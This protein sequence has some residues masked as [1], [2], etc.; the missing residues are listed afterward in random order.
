MR[1]RMNFGIVKTIL[2]AIVALGAIA[3]MGVDIAML[4]G[5]EGLASKNPANI[6]IAAVSLCAA[7]II[8]LGALLI[9]LNSSY[10]FKKSYMRAVLGVFADK[11]SYDDI[12]C[13]KQNS[14]NKELYLITKGIRQSD[15]EISFRLN[16]APERTD[17]F[18]KA[19]RDKVGDVIVDV[20]TPEKKD[21]DK[22]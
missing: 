4:A 21:K 15:G 2:L 12:V 18:I 20:F 1:F 8:A 13:F 17:D 19:M 10:T 9:L 14:L 6:A 22:K 16:I 3:I 7:L 5:A 11:I